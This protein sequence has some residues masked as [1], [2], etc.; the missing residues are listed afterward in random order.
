MMTRIEKN[1]LL[2]GFLRLYYHSTGEEKKMLWTHV[3]QTMSSDVDMLNA[4]ELF[5]E[6]LDTEEQTDYKLQLWQRLM[7]STNKIITN[8][9]ESLEHLFEACAQC[10]IV[11]FE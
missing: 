9:H 6:L 7:V 5:E 10:D 2:V 1:N 11:G 4:I 8:N 3:Q